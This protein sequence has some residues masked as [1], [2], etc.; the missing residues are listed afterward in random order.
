METG[1]FVVIMCENCECSAKLRV[2]TSRGRLR[3]TCPRCRC[4][5]DYV[6]AR[7]IRNTQ[8]NTTSGDRRA[9]I[10]PR[11]RC[12]IDE[13]SRIADQAID[14]SYA[15]SYLLNLKFMVT[16]DGPSFPLITAIDE[17]LRI[18]PYEPDYLF[19]KAEAHSLLRDDETG[20]R[21]R[22]EVLRLNPN[23]FDAYM[24]EKHFQHWENIFTY[25]GWSV[26][27]AKVPP[28]MLA[29]QQTGQNVQIVRDGLGLTLA[30]MHQVRR[31][32]FPPQIDDARWR[33]FWVE[34]PF[35][36]IFPHYSMFKHPNGIYRQEF[37]L[38]PY[39]LPKVHQ[40]NGDWLIRRF[41]EVR[42]VFLVVNDGE[43]VIYNCGFHYPTWLCGELRSVKTKLEGMSFPQDYGQRFQRSMEWYMSKSNIDAIPY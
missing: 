11:L 15:G 34:T 28:V 6:P 33:P 27:Q 39:P 38:N 5:F 10:D 4:V 26:H 9:D 30:V 25:P 21:L 19:A 42:D 29:I 36:P 43:D 22:R 1:E 17:V 32:N 23:H 18:A 16:K 12:L 24:R 2:P 20:R 3:V 7:S 13:A 41:C 8:Q 35:G 14:R 31:D 40:R 37:A